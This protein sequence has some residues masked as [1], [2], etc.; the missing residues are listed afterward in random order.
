MDKYGAKARII[1]MVT[2]ESL[3]H[4]YKLN[5]HVDTYTYVCVCAHACTLVIIPHTHLSSIS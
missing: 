4:Q 2:D 1:H 5:L 3:R